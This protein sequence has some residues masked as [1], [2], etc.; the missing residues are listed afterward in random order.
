MQIDKSIISIGMEQHE[1]KDMILE[2]FGSVTRTR[3]WKAS[4]NGRKM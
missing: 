3:I 2:V 1:Y 4:W